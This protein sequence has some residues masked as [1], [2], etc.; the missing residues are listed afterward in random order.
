MILRGVNFY[1]ISY[2][3]IPWWIVQRGQQQYFKA[4]ENLVLI[5]VNYAINQIYN[6]RGL[7]VQGELTEA[8]AS[9]LKI[10]LGH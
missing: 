2:Y 5:K 6:L 9:Y 1:E 7:L 4:L 3:R 8:V 10:K